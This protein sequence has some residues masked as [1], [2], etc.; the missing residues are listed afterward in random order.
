RRALAGVLNR[1]APGTAVANDLDGNDLSHDPAV[2]AAY[3]TDPLNVHRTTVGFGVRAFREQERVLAAIDRLAIP[4]FVIH[5]GDD[6][7]VPP[8]HRGVRTANPAV[9]RRV[10][11]NLRHE[12]HNE[13]EG[14]KVID[15]VVGWLRETLGTKAPDRGHGGGA[16]A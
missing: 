8:G 16:P 11:P 7:V 15:D 9:T 1:V 14:P 6:R 10:Y 2:A 12:M 4:T 3:R 13:P 5:G